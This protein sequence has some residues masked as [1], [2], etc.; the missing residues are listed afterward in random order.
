M[1]QKGPAPAGYGTSMSLH[2]AVRVVF[3]WRKGPQGSGALR[4]R[5]ALRCAL[6]VGR[7]GRLRAG[8]VVGEDKEGDDGHEGQ[9]NLGE[10]GG[11]ERQVHKLR[12]VVSG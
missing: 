1:A 2:R 11:C 4:R 6:R 3:S 9:R 7:V 8:S 10:H 12:S 5:D